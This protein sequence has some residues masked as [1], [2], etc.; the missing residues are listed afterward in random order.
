MDVKVRKKEF[1]FPVDLEKWIVFSPYEEN[2]FDDGKSLVGSWDE[3]TGTVK[4]VAEFRV[5]GNYSVS[6]PT[7]TVE[8]LE[9]GNSP[10]KVTL[11]NADNHP[12]IPGTAWAGTFRHHMVDLCRKLEID[13]KTV[14]ELFGIKD[15]QSQDY[16][17][18]P[19]R[20]EESTVLDGKSIVLTRTAIDRFTVAPKNTGLFTAEVCYGGKGDL[21]IFFDKNDINDIQKQLIMTT[22]CDMQLGMVTVGGENG[23]GRGRVYINRL[24]VNGNDRTNVLN[25]ICRG[26]E[27]D[28]IKILEG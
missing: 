19:V 1:D 17:K 27:C 18:S 14:D 25:M 7:S 22:L 6:E 12:V 3:M 10:D 21:I 16:F 15:I 2:A 26:E 28:P 8:L 13:K 11:K 24:T 20:F 23:V 4:I 9:N 5:D